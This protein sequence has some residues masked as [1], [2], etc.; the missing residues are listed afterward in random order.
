MTPD[1]GDTIANRDAGQ[2]AAPREGIN[3]DAGDA[4]R[5]RDAGQ[6]AAVTEGGIPDA[7]DSLT[8]NC[9][10]NY[11]LARRAFFTA[12]DSDRITFNLIL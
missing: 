6:V 12:S 5:N 1:A 9:R 3:L 8:F 4:V 7:G 2:A 10:R 11:Q